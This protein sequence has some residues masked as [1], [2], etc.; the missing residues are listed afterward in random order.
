MCEK[1]D[2]LTVQDWKDKHTDYRTTIDGEKYVM[3]LCDNRGTV[4]V[5]TEN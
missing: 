1:C 5:L 2:S 4:L 3:N